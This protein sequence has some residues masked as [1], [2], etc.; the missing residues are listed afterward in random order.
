MYDLGSISGCP[1]NPCREAQPVSHQLAY[2]PP[3]ELFNLKPNPPLRFLPSFDIICSRRAV[4]PDTQMLHSHHRRPHDHSLVVEKSNFDT[5]RACSVNS[6]IR[7]G[8]LDD[9]GDVRPDAA[10]PQR[11]EP[12]PVRERRVGVGDWQAHRGCVDRC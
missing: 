3:K 4:S 8:P 9:Y 12:L 6:V 10:A 1:A 5:V 2:L 11:R 7:F